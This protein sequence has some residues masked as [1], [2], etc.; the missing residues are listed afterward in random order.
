MGTVLGVRF[1][2]DTLTW[3]LSNKKFVST[4]DALSVPFLAGALSLKEAQSLTGKLNNVCQ[5]CPFLRA[6]RFPLNKFVASFGSKVKGL[7]IPPRPTGPPLSAIVFHSDAAGACFARIRGPRVPH[8][9]D[10]DSGGASIRLDHS[11]HIVFYT[12]VS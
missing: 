10:G 4:T 9:G 12:H 8:S 7:P 1:F 2:T 6:F 3:R 11:G 5:M